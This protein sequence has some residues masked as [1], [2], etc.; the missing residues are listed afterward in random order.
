MPW[1]ELS[2]MDQREEFVR[3]AL[4]PGANKRELCR[5]IGISGKTGYKLLGRYAREGRA[6]LADRPRRPRHSPGRTP[7]AVEQEVLRIRTESNDAWGGRKI[8]AAMQRSGHAEVPAASTITAILRRHGRLGVRAHEH[9]GAYERFERAAPNELWQMDFKGHFPLPAGRCHPLTV[10]DDHSRYAV[11]LAACGDEQDATVRER[12][13]AVFRRYGLP[14]AMLMDNGS[15]WGDAGDQPHTVFTAWLLRLGVRVSHGRPY[16]PQTQGKDE[17]FH[18]TLKAELLQARSFRDL[19]HCQ[20]AFDSWRHLYNHHRPHDALALAVPADRYC[21]SPRPFPETLS[22]IE[23][24]P[25]DSVRKVDESGCISFKNRPWRIGKA[26]RGQP[27][28][29][30]ATVED[31]VFSVHYC[32]HRIAAIDLRTASP[33][34]C[35]VVDNASALPTTPQAPL[36]Q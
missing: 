12:L 33:S 7:D 8:R 34:A 22:P 32:T 35:G 25:A 5:R 9:P 36:Q 4:K 1:T 30:R 23:Y 31:G 16:H 17:R 6:G 27:I 19:A 18:R 26:F 28:A 13:V 3:L 2:V 21:A 15:P 29:V 24:G 14:L 20:S 11:G 10:L